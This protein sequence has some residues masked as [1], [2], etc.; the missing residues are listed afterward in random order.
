VEV[1]RRQR[2]EGPSERLAAFVM[3]DPGIPRAGMRI[4]EGGE[5]T[6]GTLSPMLDVGIGLGYVP[7]SLAAPETE[8]TIDLRGRPRRAR[9]VRK[10]FYKRE[11]C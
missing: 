2:E 11:E 6:S 8:I 9:I 5:V 1:L 7:A 3:E 4:A 10:P